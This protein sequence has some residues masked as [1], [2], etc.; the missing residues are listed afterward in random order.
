[1]TCFL[2]DDEKHCTDVLHI[3]LQRHCPA[4]TVAGV[5]NDAELALE[6]LQQSAPDLVFLDI[7]MP[8]MNGFDWLKRCPPQ[9]QF[10]LIFTTAYDQYAIKAFKFNALDYLLKPIDAMELKVAVEK[11]SQMA[12][13]SPNHWRAADVLRE[14]PIPERIALPIGTEL[15][16]IQVADIL[17]C[18]AEGSYVNFFVKGQPRPLM[19][20]KSL[21]EV[22]DLLQ[23]PTVFVRC[24]H[25]F[26]INV[27]QV[28]KIIRSDNTAIVMA[29]DAHIPV[30]RAKKAELLSWVIRL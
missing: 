15:H 23:Q 27:Q 12:A 1:M 26:L 14:Q 6:A 3:M 18:A 20:S 5:F 16:V 24:H 17:Y 29:N 7:E 2:I 19:V 25:S 11:V 22:E 28:K 21:R 9:R 8:Q 10:R 13:P 30:A 4:L